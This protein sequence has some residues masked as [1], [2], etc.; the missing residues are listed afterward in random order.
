M[1]I[2]NGP[3]VGAAL[4]PL[5]PANGLNA[6][7]NVAFS[8]EFDA[9][10]DAPLVAAFAA[11]APQ[12]VNEGFNLPHPVTTYTLQFA[13]QAASVP[14]QELAGYRYLMNNTAGQLVREFALHGNMLVIA[15]HD[16]TRW[17]Q[18]WANVRKLLEKCGPLLLASQRS[19]RAVA[20]QYT[21]KFTW[22]DASKP[23]PLKLVLRG[24]AR[25]I[26]SAALDETGPWH[27]MFGYV[28]Q[29][30]PAG[31]AQSRVDNVNLSVADEGSFRALN[32]FALY[33]Y[34]PKVVAKAPN[35]FVS[36]VLPSL[37]NSAHDD[38]K[39]LLRELLSDEVQTMIQ[40]GAPPA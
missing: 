5:A 26:V 13:M 18:V 32:I 20:M 36:A 3:T 11:L 19:V 40:L 17:P 15:I 7:V 31:W 12:L 8:I 34:L 21:D 1:A 33:R 14:A 2:T 9:P 10:A 16:Y 4:T 35:D 6:I 39:Q 22:R 37:F 27:S 30:G 24:D 29:V 23:L 38:N 25:H 28:K